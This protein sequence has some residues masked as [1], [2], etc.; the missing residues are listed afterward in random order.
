MLLRTDSVTV[1]FV[2]NKFLLAQHLYQF[3]NCQIKKNLSH[4][5]GFRK[6]LHVP[7]SKTPLFTATRPKDKE[8]TCSAAMAS[9]DIL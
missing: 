9:L 6:K 2:R 5:L 8:N 3:C 4:P 7:K 1:E